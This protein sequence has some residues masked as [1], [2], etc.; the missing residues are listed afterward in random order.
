MLRGGGKVGGTIA[1]LHNCHISL[2]MW[3]QNKPFISLSRA[4]YPQIYLA[5]VLLPLS[6]SSSFKVQEKVAKSEK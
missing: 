1:M 4:G 6:L 2:N 5:F 3:S